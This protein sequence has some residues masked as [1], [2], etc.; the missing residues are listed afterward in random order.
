M[1]CASEASEGCALC[2]NCFCLCLTVC[3]CVC[4]CVYAYHVPWLSDWVPLSVGTLALLVD[5]ISTVLLC[6]LGR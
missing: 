6:W 1:S 3:I 4:A 2:K 5:L